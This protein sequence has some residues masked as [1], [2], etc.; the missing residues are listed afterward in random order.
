LAVADLLASKLGLTLYGR[1][2]VEL[3]AKNAQV[4]EQVV[5]TLDEKVRSE[6]DSWVTELLQ[7]GRALSAYGY[8]IN[9]KKV[10]FS[11]AAHGNAVIVGRGGN[12]AIPP[13]KRIGLRLV[14][15]LE[16]R[17][18]FVMGKLRLSERRA[19]DHIA[20]TEREQRR[21][22]KKNFG[23]DPGDPLNYHLVVNIALVKP[24]AILG[25]VRAMIEECNRAAGVS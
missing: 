13:E 5:D 17:L 21:F 4:S 25:V 23:A 16:A 15:P 2:I 19:R 22:V 11:I 6:L 18:E 9:L 14:A 1:E 7:S 20:R 8:L 10:L 12:F 3:I 24:E